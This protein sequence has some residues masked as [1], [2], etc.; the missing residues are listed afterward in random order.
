M[1]VLVDDARAVAIRRSKEQTVNFIN[2]SAVDVY[3]DTDAMRLNASA[4]GA[5]PSGTKIAASG[6][7]VGWSSFPGVVWVRAATKTTLEVTP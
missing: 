1:Q 4:L 6:G 5:V 3:Y 2:E 7:T